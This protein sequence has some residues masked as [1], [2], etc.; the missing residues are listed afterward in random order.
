LAAKV[1]EV[2]SQAERSCYFECSE[3]F[4]SCFLGQRR[5]DGFHSC[6]HTV[7]VAKG[8]LSCSAQHW[9][10]STEPKM[11]ILGRVRV[12]LLC[13]LP[14]SVRTK[15]Q[16]V[17]ALR[18][19]KSHATGCRDTQELSFHIRSS[20]GCGKV[21]R[22]G[23]KIACVARPPDLPGAFLSAA[24]AAFIF[25]SAPICDMTSWRASRTSP[26]RLSS[27]RAPPRLA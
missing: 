17:L 25:H 10:A 23:F 5:H 20:D 4:S 1:Q 2:L 21:R 14:I 26:Y 19:V 9:W 12:V 24:A 8:P 22:K 13:R 6:N 15:K 3:S 16:A 11:L 7:S 18:R 27:V